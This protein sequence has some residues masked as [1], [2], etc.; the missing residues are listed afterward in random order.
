VTG[1]ASAALR[2]AVGVPWLGSGSL[3][4]ATEGTGPYQYAVTGGSLP[5]GLTLDA[6]SGAITGTPAA[7]AAG[8]YTVTVTAT[9]SAA[10]PL[11]GSATF[12]LPVAAGH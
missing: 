4:T 7:A 8:S 9:D 11:T 2:G 3:V 10:T 1:P 12:T 6:T 5:A